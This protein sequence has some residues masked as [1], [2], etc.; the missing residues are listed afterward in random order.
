MRK[1]MSNK[2]ATVHPIATNKDAPSRIV[3]SGKL[4]IR[5]PKHDKE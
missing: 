1:D 4:T 3:A 2:A 5:K